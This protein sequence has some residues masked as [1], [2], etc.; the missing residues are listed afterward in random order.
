MLFYTKSNIIQKE[1]LITKIFFQNGAILNQTFQAYE[2]HIPYILQFMIDYNLYGMNLINLNSI[3]YRCSLQG[4]TIEEDSQ[5]KSSMDLINSQMYL[6]TS[7]TRQS[8]CE[9]EVDARAS[10]ILNRQNITEKLE[11]N[12][13]LAAIWDEEKTRRA[14]VGLENAKS[15]LLYPKTPS[16]I[17]LPPTSSD[18]YQKSQLLKRLNIISQVFYCSIV[19]SNVLYMYIFILILILFVLD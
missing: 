8:M 1:Y 4:C 2:A 15:Q 17:I 11:L 5:N 18:I 9:L 3:K 19:L 12:P 14:A 13:G 6:P 7:I 10:D 16:K